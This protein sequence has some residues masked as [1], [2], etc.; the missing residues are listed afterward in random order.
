M[1]PE[2]PRLPQIE[3]EDWDKSLDRYRE[4]METDDKVY[5]IF[6]TLA[7]HPDGMRRWMVFANHVLFKSTLSARDREILILRIGWICQAEYEWAQHVLIAKRAGITDEE[8]DRIKQGPGAPG[9]S[10][11]EALLLTATGELH[12]DACISDATWAG[13]KEHYSDQQMVDIIFAVGNYNLV[14]M[15]LNSLGVPLDD[16]LEGF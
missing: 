7:G 14:S 16:F 15:M 1:R 13:L 11:K 10:D 8:I 5:N 12:G 3:A 9:W 4:N 2:K 6:K